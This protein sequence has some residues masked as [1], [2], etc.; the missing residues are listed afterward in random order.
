MLG[1]WIHESP[2]GNLK[3]SFVCLELYGVFGSHEGLLVMLL[4]TSMT[5]GMHKMQFVNWMVRMAGE[6]SFLTTLEAEVVVAAAD[7]EGDVVAL[8]VQI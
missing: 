1:I 5:A 8:V 6:L 2:S 4:L 3:T 7:V